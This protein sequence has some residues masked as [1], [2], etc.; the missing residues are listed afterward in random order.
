MDQE[1][2]LGVEFHAFSHQ[3]LELMAEDNAILITWQ[4]KGSDSSVHG[5]LRK[6][7]SHSTVSLL[8]LT[9]TCPGE[10]SDAAS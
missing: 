10:E 9:K 2:L 8:S 5:S 3:S 6:S 4:A 7:V 1:V